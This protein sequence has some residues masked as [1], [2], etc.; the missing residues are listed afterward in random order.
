MRHKVIRFFY[1]QC[2]ASIDLTRV[3]VSSSNRLQPSGSFLAF[4]LVSP[5][6]FTVSYGH[7][8]KWN[9]DY[10]HS[11]KGRIITFDI[12]QFTCSP[13]SPPPPK[14]T[15]CHFISSPLF[16][17]LPQ[18]SNS[19]LD[20]HNGLSMRV[21]VCLRAFW[22]NHSAYVH[23]THGR[24]TNARTLAADN[25]SLRF[26][27][28]IVSNIENLV[29]IIRAFSIDCDATGRSAMERKAKHNPYLVGQSNRIGNFEGLLSRERER[30]GRT[31]GKS[32]ENILLASIKSIFGL[33]FGCAPS[34][35]C[36]FAHLVG[37]HSLCAFDWLEEGCAHITPH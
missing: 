35:Q 13:A 26:D 36:V 5:I 8:C 16:A 22:I 9:T 19:N 14:H 17:S 25:G 31:N 3:G 37:L 21:R 18:Q 32:N 2:H 20:Q 11:R 24:E 33:C 6:D 7:Y 23:H 28:S 1:C 10:S 15:I 4:S 29:S 12:H 34:L 30:H 27:K